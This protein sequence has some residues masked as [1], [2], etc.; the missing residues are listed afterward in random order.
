MRIVLDIM[1]L[2]LFGIGLAGLFFARGAIAEATS[3]ITLSPGSI[4]LV[5]GCLMHEL[6]HIKD[7]PK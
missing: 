4:F 5:G 3:A 6:N 2:I 1:G 7:R